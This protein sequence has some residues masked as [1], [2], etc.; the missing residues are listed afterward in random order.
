M[1]INNIENVTNGSDK[2]YQSTK[3]DVSFFD[4]QKSPQTVIEERYKG[5]LPSRIDYE[6]DIE[7]S[8]PISFIKEEIFQIQSDLL[9]LKYDLETLLSKVY[10]KSSINQNLEEAHKKLWEEVKKENNITDTAP[11]YVSFSEYKYAERTMSTSCRRVLNEYHAAVAQTSFGYIYDLRRLVA[12][13]QNEAVCIRDILLYKFGEDYE[14]DSQRQTALQFD[15][16]AKMASH[17]SQRTK[18]TL[19]SSPAEIPVSELDKVTKKQAVEFQAFFSIRL[20]A[21]QDECQNVLNFLKRDYVDNCDIFY[22]RYL[23]QS[24]QFKKDISSN[25]ELDFLTTTFS[26]ETPILSEE[27][28]IARNV[29]NSNFGMI[30]TD[31]VQRNQ[32]I[33]SNVDNLFR[34]IESKRKYSNYIYQL[35]FKGQTKPVI[36]TSP[37]EDKYEGIFN[38]T[39]LPYNMESD[40]ISNHASLDNLN[41]DHHPQY[42]L[43]NGGTITGNIQVDPNIKIDGVHL[44]THSHTGL[45]GSERIRSTDIDYD[46]PRTSI[47]NTLVKPNSIEV[48]SYNADIIDGGV[49]VLDGIIDIEVDDS[50]V[51]DNHEIIIEVIEL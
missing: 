3:S 2:F 10:I 34:I 15:A 16:W 28:N 25:L 50:L 44:S 8:L 19:I 9:S 24:L 13:I 43:K 47:S 29:I 38:N 46:S 4:E 7:L 1:S 27:L 48:I 20:N 41:E 35:S 36:I 37:K 18:K 23:S 11:D 31:L 32:I 12:F 45:D 22:E 6:Q 26:R 30:L 21:L 14:D 49:P 42:L 33:N 39:I 17:F 40:L 51:T 5:L